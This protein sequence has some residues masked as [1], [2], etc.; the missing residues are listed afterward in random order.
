[1]SFADEIASA[2][3][4]GDF[5]SLSRRVP[6]MAAMG[7]EVEVR[8]G[9]LRGCMRFDDALIGNFAI[10]ALHGGTL[11]ALLES[12][13]AFELMWRHGAEQLPRVVGIT[14]EYLRSG[15]ALDTHAR[16]EVVRAGRR[17]ANVHALA[18]QDDPGSPIA[19]AHVR[20]L[21]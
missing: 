21:R 14:V 1:M 6:L 5:G 15:R 8:G 9:E 3:Q 20:F 11:G 18:W 12:V 7:I 2:R 17:V 19:A 10:R 4:S 16:A 13:A